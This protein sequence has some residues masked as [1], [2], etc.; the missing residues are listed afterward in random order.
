MDLK[1]RTQRNARQLRSRRHRVAN[2]AE[3]AKR[4]R[5]CRSFHCEDSLL[6]LSTFPTAAPGEKLVVFVYRV[7][8]CD[9]IWQKAEKAWFPGTQRGD[10]G[11]WTISGC[12]SCSGL[13]RSRTQKRLYDLFGVNVTPLPGH[14][15]SPSCQELSMELMVRPSSRGIP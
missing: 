7:T 10:S 8:W 15:K 1:C 12:A 6:T 3:L 5:F 13:L 9:F 2:N 14:L 11:K 4:A